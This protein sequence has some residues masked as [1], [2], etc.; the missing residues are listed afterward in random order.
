MGGGGRGSRKHVPVYSF[1]STTLL[2][3]LSPPA[4][5]PHV[6]CHVRTVLKLAISLLDTLTLTSISFHT[7]SPS[8]FVTLHPY[9]AQK[10]RAACLLPV[11]QQSLSGPEPPKQR[12]TPCWLISTCN[13]C[14]IYPLYQHRERLGQTARRFETLMIRTSLP[15]RNLG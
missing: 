13:T 15:R 9:P 3:G 11:G 10:P 7:P 5:C 8:T 14:M 2:S 6:D 12:C 1:H 4:R